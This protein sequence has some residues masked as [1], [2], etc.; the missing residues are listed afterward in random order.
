MTKTRVAVAEVTPKLMPGTENWKVL[1]DKLQAIEAEIFVLNELPFGGW[2][3]AGSEF[4]EDVFKASV[5]AHDAGVAALETLGVPNVLGSRLTVQ[6][7]VRVNCGFLWTKD[8]GLKDFYTKQHVPSSPG[9]WESTWYGSGPRTNPVIEVAGLKVGML[10]CTDIM[11]NEHARGYG[12]KGADLIVVPRAMPPITRDLFDAAMTMGAVASGCYVASSNRTGVNDMGEA[13][14]GRGCV[15][16]PAGQTVAQT[17][18]FAD[19]TFH[20]VDTDFARWK[21]S[22]YP[23]DVPE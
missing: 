11:F 17:N 15:Y 6:N 8:E 18:M 10:I 3:S 7:G 9:Y 5:A 2:I 20:D 19:V 16:N 1:A 22:I 4:D 12:R 21:Q 23:C 14:E 13:F